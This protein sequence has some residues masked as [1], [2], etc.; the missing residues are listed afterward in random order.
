MLSEK[1]K[2]RLT[3]LVI[4]L[5]F[6]SIVGYSLNAESKGKITIEEGYEEISVEYYDPEKITDGVGGRDYFNKS[7]NATTNINEKSKL[8]LKIDLRSC[9]VEVDD[10]GEYYGY[11][12]FKMDVE[13][14]G[15]LTDSLDPNKLILK[16]ENVGDN[17][18]SNT[19]WFR[20]SETHIDNG[21]QGEDLFVQKETFDLNSNKFRAGGLLGVQ[22]LRDEWGNP[23]TIEIQ[24]ELK[25]LSEDVQVTLD[26]NIQGTFEE[27]NM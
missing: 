12:T 17:S 2:P 19:P 21:S 5:V 23:Y 25:G 7:V 4:L 27:W 9:L 8:R 20:G 11:Q 26:L 24:A 22:V 3:L 10:K 14:I 16:A 13:C 1:N 15:D 18:L 6:V